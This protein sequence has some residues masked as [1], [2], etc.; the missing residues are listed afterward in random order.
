M[1]PSI[2]IILK[3]TRKF[4]LHLILASQTLGHKGQSKLK[5]TILSNTSVKIIG[6]NSYNTLKSLG[7]ETN[8]PL[9]DLQMMRKHE[10]YIKSGEK[11]ERKL[12]V[13][14]GL[15]ITKLL[16]VKR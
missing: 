7:K 9:A 11:K 4:G 6:N 8:I 10:F 1:T 14:R 12:K 2:D 13:P 5:E 16:Y 3:E 15:A